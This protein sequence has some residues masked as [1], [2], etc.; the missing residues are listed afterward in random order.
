MEGI[1]QETNVYVCVCVSDGCRV[2]ALLLPDQKEW[3]LQEHSAE[4]L[5]TPRKKPGMLALQFK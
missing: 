1:Q 5:Q 4:E 2:R 3:K